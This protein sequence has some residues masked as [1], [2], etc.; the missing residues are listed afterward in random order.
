MAQHRPTPNTKYQLPTT[1]FSIRVHLRKSAAKGFAF[2]L[3]NYQLPITNYRVYRG[4]NANAGLSPWGS[5][6]RAMFSTSASML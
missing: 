3:A 6:V 5:G 4:N 1:C 2:G